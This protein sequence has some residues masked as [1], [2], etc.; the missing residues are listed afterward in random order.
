MTQFSPANTS[1]Q[2]SDYPDKGLYFRLGPSDIL[3]GQV[4]AEVIADDG[5]ATVVDPEL[6]RRLRQRPRRGPRG[7]VRRRSGGEVVDTITYDPQAQTFDAEVGRRLAADAD[8][9]ALIGFEETSRVLAAL[10]EQGIGPHDIPTY[11][12]RRQHRQRRSASASTP[13]SSRR[14]E[15]TRRGP[16]APAAGPRSASGR[17]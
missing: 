3:Q 2:F 1:K 17:S 15:P 5:H 11:L 14:T 10:V 6:R 12:R 7:V 13:A 9:I 4:L 16:A 8:A